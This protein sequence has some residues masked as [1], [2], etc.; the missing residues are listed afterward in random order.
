MRLAATAWV[1]DAVV[2][3]FIEYAMK[4]W[5]RI[6]LFVTL[7]LA[8]PWAWS[9]E[10]PVVF[11]LCSIDVDFAPVAKV[12]GTGHYQYLLAQAARR[13]GIVLER[14]IAPRRRCLDE[15]RSGASDGMVGGFAAERA[16]FAV[17]PMA[18]NGPEVS[19][20]LGAVRFY[21]YRRKGAPLEWD[22][23]DLQAL[24]DG[25]IGVESA[26]VFVT[27]RLRE[28]NV[29]F[30][31]GGKTLEQNFGKLMAGR[32]A[33]VVGMDIEAS[34]LIQ[35]RHAGKIEKAGKLFDLTP[36]YL[37]LSQQFHAKHPDLAERYWD[38]IEELRNGADYRK[39]QL[40]HP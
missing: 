40:E 22:G 26:F 12:D 24:G 20:A 11:K 32:V 28:L 23:Q 10:E 13:M 5:L 33:G 14:R 38:T 16:R 29:P 1:C 31:D 35:L 30:D 9:A 19:K 2:F 34:R 27:D 7:L 3:L 21:V 6:S 17:F 18:G 4:C 39:Y 36:M 37:M 25:T 8:L 15:V